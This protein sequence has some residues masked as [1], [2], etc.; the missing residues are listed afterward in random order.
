MPWEQG[1]HRCVNSHPSWGRGVPAPH[2]LTR[3]VSSRATSPAT[4]SPPEQ[5]SI[6]SIRGL[7]QQSLS[8]FTLRVNSLAGGITPK[9]ERIAKEFSVRMK[10]TTKLI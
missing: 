2:I 9:A 10:L 4:L 3:P 6:Q 5:H 8:L 1:D 7:L